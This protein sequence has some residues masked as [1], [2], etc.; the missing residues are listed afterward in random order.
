MWKLSASVVAVALVAL[1]GEG[2][3][4]AVKGLARV[5]LDCRDLATSKPSSH[6]LHLTGCEV[7]YAGIGYRGGE[8]IEEVFLPA[9]PAGRAMAAPIVIVTRDPAALALA[10]PILGRGRG[11]A[12]DQSLAAVRKIVEAARAH[13]AIDGLARAGVIERL[14]TRRILSGLT[15]TPVA[16]DALL[17]DVDGRPDFLRPV[18]ALA[19]GLLLGFLPFAIARQRDAAP[20]TTAN[21]RSTTHDVVHSNVIAPAAARAPDAGPTSFATVALPRLLLLNLSIASGPESVETAPALGDRNTVVDILRGVVPDLAMDG[22]GRTL[23]RADRSLRIDLGPHDPVA[24]VVID[25]RGEAGAALVREILLM[26]GWRA[27]A[28]KTGLFVS[29]DELAVMSALARPRPQ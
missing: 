24:T 7:E 17:I 13:Q 22:N 19:T 23:A 8:S 10:Q 26:T 6:R 29:G 14:R 25:A 9:R 11:V 28:P 5:D 27:F 15:A 1:G 18:L 20:I 16:A 21:D 2:L 12:A 3:Y 4:H